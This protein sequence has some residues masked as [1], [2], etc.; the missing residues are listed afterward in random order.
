MPAT[1]DVSLRYGTIAAIFSAL[2]PQHVEKI[3]MRRAFSLAIFSAIAPNS[4]GLR[5]LA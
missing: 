4:G 1:Q 3:Y 5:K 2:R